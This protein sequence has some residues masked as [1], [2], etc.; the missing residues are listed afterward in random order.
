[1]KPCSR[2]KL[3]L[4][5]K[6]F[7]DIIV[8]RRR[9]LVTLIAVATVVLVWFVPQMQTDPTL[10]S[11]VDKSTPAYLD[12]REFTGI[13]GNE[14]FILIA[15]KSPGRAVDSETLRA[16]VRITTK[17]QSL[18]KIQ[19]VVSLSTIKL[20]QKKGELFGN[21][22]ILQ[23]NGD[24]L[25]LPPEPELEQIKKALPVTDLLI[26]PDRKTVGILLR[27]QDK[28]KFDVDAAKVLRR[29][30]NEII[31]KE[32][33]AHT[34]FSMVGPPFIRQAIVRYNIQT[35]II[36]GV[37]CL[38]IGTIVS[39]YVFRSVRVTAITNA[40]L[41]LCV[42][43]ILGFMSLLGIPLNSTTV[44]SFGFI[45]IA[46]IEI[47]IHMVVR[48]H[49]FHQGTHDKEGAIK[50]AVRWLA[51]P[52]FMCCATTSI[53]FGTLMVSS[54]PMVRQLGFIMS[55]GIMIAY[56]L[57]IILTPAFFMRLKQ[58]DASEQNT[59]IRGW[60][61]NSL[62]KLERSIFKHSRLYVIIGLLSAAILLSGAPLIR[63]DTQI[64]R[65]LSSKTPEVQDLHFVESNLTAVNSVELML[66]GQPGEFKNAAMWSKIAELENKLKSIP[67]VAGTDSLLPLLDYLNTLLSDSDTKQE[68]LANESKVPQFLA[69]VNMGAEGK[70]VS[71]RFVN[72]AYD[73]AH[74]SV[75]IVNSPDHPIGEV[76]DKIQAAADSVMKDA[77]KVVVT[78]DLVVVAKQTSELIRDQ[79]RSMLLAGLLITIVMMIQMGSVVLGLVSLIPNIPP[80]AAVFGIMGWF[81][82]AL[83]A[84]TIFAAT[85]AVGLAVDNTIHFLTQ[86]KREIILDPDRSVEE[87]VRSAYRLTAKQISSWS[88][89]TLLGFLALI[90][91]P[92]RP[93]VF[94]GILGCASL[95]LGLYGD[96]I[97]VQSLILSSNWL[98]S[99]VRKVVEREN[100]KMTSRAMGIPEQ[101]GLSIEASCEDCS[102]TR[103]KIG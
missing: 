88:T 103:R 86:L 66:Q 18:D 8:D 26:S 10:E 59:V 98:K 65:M 80:V 1:M 64:L 20:F 19:E 60:L 102:E 78:G 25:T 30:L 41:S 32:A 4:A 67:E 91:S 89:I 72:D 76:I 37:L 61:D 48:Y 77:A 54:I 38:L 56:G 43:W 93:V 28:W 44:L 23:K 52:C 96:L 36:F 45:P 35:G 79:I 100:G 17:L 12:H 68:L 13:F 87:S 53:G 81:G 3:D 49:F 90:I 46:T 22:P 69:L 29:E 51:R 14:E 55:V 99:A 84:V 11:G 92:F 97:F 82:I 74:I 34:Q 73:V 63:S 33:P 57:A 95:C 47:V 42:I 50:Q 83:D 101:A 94:F 5:N 21:Y 24:N 75:R 70:R 58:L 16:L 27:M 39:A 85:V 15:L 2:D 40:I 71:R 62:D 31:K 6:N 9:L 7:L